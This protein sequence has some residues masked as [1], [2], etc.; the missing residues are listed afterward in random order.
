MR[1]MSS[2]IKIST[3]KDDGFY[4]P[5]EWHQHSGVLMLWPERSENWKE[6]AQPAR[7]AFANVIKAISEFEHVTVGVTTTVLVVV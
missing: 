7:I 6:K 1:T 4:M 3:P 5:A 2:A